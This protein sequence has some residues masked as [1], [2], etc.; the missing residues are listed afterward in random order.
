MRSALL[1]ITLTLLVVCLALTGTISLAAAEK[2]SA[3]P[4]ATRQIV[5]F[6]DTTTDIASQEAIVARAGGQWLKPLRLINA[7]VVVA[8]PAN[9]RAL[10]AHPAVLRIDP[11][12]TVY[13]LD[14]P[15][16]PAAKPP[17][18]PKPTPTPGPAQVVP[19]GVTKIGAEQA[20]GSST[21]ADVK[22]AVVDTGID[23]DHPDLVDNVRG[24]FNAINPRKQPDDDNGHGTHVAGIIAA[25]N[26]GFG[27]VGVAP[28]ASLYAVKV[29]GASGSG[30]LSD[31]IEG[32]GWCADNGI[33][34][35]NMSLGTSADVDSFHQAIATVAQKGVILVASAGNSG[36]GF[37]TVSYPA[38]YDEVIAVAATDQNNVA[39]YFSSTGPAVELAAPGVNIYSTV[40]GGGYTSMSG[41]SMAAPH[42]SGTA[43]LVIAAYPGREATWVRDHLR[44]TATDL[45]VAGC[46]NTYG[47]GLV[48][49]DNAVTV[50]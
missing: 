27:V 8:P 20:W 42:V 40:K 25:A 33:Q 29:L 17:K 6:E 45:G 3:E 34:A 39:A 36:P 19:W 12:I 13:A 24:G 7:A 38:K 10:A 15:V 21:G 2:P 23:L 32:L 46:D 1:R 5:V 11:D 47:C 48:N 30:Y 43:A 50:P 9:Q 28:E 18:P 16:V 35:V 44:Q 22:V 26:N 4:A 41:T 37:D 14:Q 31:I 49:A